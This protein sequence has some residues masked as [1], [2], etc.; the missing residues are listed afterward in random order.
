MSASSRLCL[1]V[2]M[3]YGLLW[4]IPQ[5]SVTAGVSFEIHLGIHYSR[6]WSLKYILRVQSGVGS[7]G[8]FHRYNLGL[9]QISQSIV[10]VALLYG[11]PSSRLYVIRKISNSIKTQGRGMK[12]SQVDLTSY[13]NWIHLNRSVAKIFEGRG[14]PN[15]YWILISRGVPEHLRLLD[16]IKEFTLDLPLGYHHLK[17]AP[18]LL[19][20]KT[21][22]QTNSTLQSFCPQS[23]YKWATNRCKSHSTQPILTISSIFSLSNQAE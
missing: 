12:L 9:P 13:L 15:V 20:S 4:G 16:Y 18:L 3:G 21:I 14:V 2:S 8:L 23:C 6:D 5:E 11:I 19:T 1:W 22:S 10:W 17:S 7:W